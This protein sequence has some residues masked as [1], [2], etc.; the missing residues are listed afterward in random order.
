MKTALKI[1]G[2]L[3]V[4]LGIGFTAL[5]LLFGAAAGYDSAVSLAVDIASYGVGVAVLGAV[6]VEGARWLP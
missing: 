5:V 2:W 6:V 1:V 4:G 3:L